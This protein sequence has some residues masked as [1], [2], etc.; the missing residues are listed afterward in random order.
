MDIFSTEMV[1]SE[2][3]E[4]NNISRFSAG[5]VTGSG[6]HLM[7]SLLDECT[8]VFFPDLFHLVPGDTISMN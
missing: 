8:P 2:A 5:Y 4:Q 6:L 3:D 7:F 1:V